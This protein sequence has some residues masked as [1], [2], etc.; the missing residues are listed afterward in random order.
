MTPLNSIVNMA[1]LLIS[2]FKEATEDQDPYN[3]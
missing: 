2:Q 3:D 1:E